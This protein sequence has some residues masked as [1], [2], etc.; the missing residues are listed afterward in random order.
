M[1]KKIIKRRKTRNTI[2]AAM[3]II[4]GIVIALLTIYLAAGM[5]L[6]GTFLPVYIAGQYVIGNQIVRYMLYFLLF[7][8]FVL[9]V[10]LI[11]NGCNYFR[12]RMKKRK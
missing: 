9:A 10:M 3:F 7:A 4:G 2:M 12:L 6:S 5:W 8:V 11:L 1:N